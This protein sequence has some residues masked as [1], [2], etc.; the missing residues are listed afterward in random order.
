MNKIEI[1]TRYG[2]TVELLLYEEEL[3]EPKNVTCPGSG[4]LWIAYPDDCISQSLKYWLAMAQG[5]G[6]IDEWKWMAKS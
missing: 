6:L 3:V 4:T 5:C 2:V 1:E